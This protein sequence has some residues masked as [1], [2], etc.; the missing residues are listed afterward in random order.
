MRE[1]KNNIPIVNLKIVTENDIYKPSYSHDTDY[2][3]DIKVKINKKEVN[4]KLID[5]DFD[6]IEPNSCK[7]FGTGLKVSIPEG[8]GLF[9]IPRSSTG[10]KLNCQLANTI[11]MI[12]SGYR[13]EIKIRV[14]N[15]G[16]ES[17]MLEDGQRLC[18]MYIL[19]K[20]HINPIYVEDNQE[21]KQG[22]RGGGIG[23]TG[24]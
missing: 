8:W 10:F 16:N 23:S 18:Q 17:V 19:P 13:D 22:D 2:C 24:V 6:I 12:D 15:F 4:G 9:I 1:F 21:F 3:M 14:H 20:F 5:S 7:T 11:G